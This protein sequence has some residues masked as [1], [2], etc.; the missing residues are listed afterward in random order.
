M[1]LLSRVLCVCALAGV[2]A[3]GGS[4]PEPAKTTAT[5]S[6]RVDAATAGS[7][8]GSVKFEG[9]PPAAETIR[10]SKDCVTGP[11][12]NPQGESVLVGADGGMQNVFVY[13]RDGLN[14]SYTFDPPAAPAELKQTGCIYRPRV[15]GV[16]VGQPIDVVNDDP[17]L[18]NVHA[19]PMVNSEFNKHQPQQGQHMTHVF[20][21]PEVMVRF[22]CDVHPWMSSYVGVVAHPF[23]AVSDQT[24]HFDI[25]GVPPGTYTVEA[26]H[27]KYG[28]QSSKVTVGDHQ[29]QSIAFTFKADSK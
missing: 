10:L 12:P 15:M 21:A 29:D 22:K 2:A 18:H 20:T 28:R 6:K 8:S 14:T 1:N 11:G 27:E 24:G 16:Q 17:T 7:I 19:L 23:F 26:W 4:K 25:K 5:Q 9:T 3:C 13:V